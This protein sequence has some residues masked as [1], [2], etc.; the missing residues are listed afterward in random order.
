MSLHQIIY[1]SCK[2][3]IN[4]VNDGQQVFSYDASFKDASGD[5]VKRLFTYQ[6]PML[7]V[8]VIMTEEL[9]LTFPKSFIYR[10]MDNGACALTLNTYLGRDYMGSAG[11]FGN[12]LSHVVYCDDG[13]LPYYPAEFFGSSMLRDHMEYDEV[14]N[15]DKPDFLPEPVCERGYLV[16][17]DAV[18]EFLGIEDRLEI[19]KNMLHAVL[20][21]ETE[22]K[23]VVICDEPENVIL[24]IA[25]IQYALPLEFAL[26]INFSTYEFDPS[27]SYSQICGVIPKG[28]RYTPESRK[29]HFTFDLYD[30]VCAEF[31]KDI[32]FFDFIDTAFSFSYESLQ[33]FH[34]FILDGY[35]CDKAD[36]RMYAAYRLYTM[37][38]DGLASL[39]DE[40]IKSALEF[41]TQ[42]AKPAEHARIAE[43]LF[44]QK[45]NILRAKGGTFLVVMKYLMSENISLSEEQ[46]SLIKR[47]YVN[48][49]LIELMTNQSGENDYMEFY[50][51]ALSTSSAAGM[52]LDQEL[53]KP[54]NH[55]KLLK[56]VEN[57]T[58]TWKIAFVISKISEYVKSTHVPIE[59]LAFE[60]SLGQTYDNLVRST[61]TNSSK[62]GYFLVTRILNS[63]ASDCTYLINMTLNMEGTILDLPDGEREAA[64]MWKYWGQL[65]VEH[66]S[67]H[68]GKACE[69]LNDFER[70][71]EIF[72]LYTLAIA[73]VNEPGALQNLFEEHYNGFAKKHPEYAQA[74]ASK[75][76]ESYYAKLKDSRNEAAQKAK[77]ALFEFVKSNKMDV[78]F[79]ENLVADLVLVIPFDTPS[80]EHGYLID[81]C[82]AYLHDQMKKPVRGKLLI[83]KI[84]H[85]LGKCK[86]SSAF[87]D[88]LD[89]LEKLTADQK[90]NL[91]PVSSQGL[92]DYLEWLLPKVCDHCQKTE[93]M[94]RVYNLFEM[95]RNAQEQYFATCAKIY[96]KQ[97]KDEKDYAALCEFLGFVFTLGTPNVREEVGK[98]LRKLNKQK[99]TALDEEVKE[100][101]KKDSSAL[102]YWHDIKEVAQESSGLMSSMTNQL[103]NITDLFKKKK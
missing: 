42:Y 76:I 65:M 43:C 37:L 60:T 34:R 46:E 57:E 85:A 97:S 39:S 56:V 78:P 100:R 53:A 98:S 79:I 68:F 66:H 103:K 2:R 20:A 77:A 82:F 84:A 61:Y 75:I 27:L 99:L 11:R 59:E 41:A 69:V 33:D 19:F 95:P 91:A 13:N 72:T 35:T 73:A 45:E 74:Y 9:A 26:G 51:E 36:V 93:E 67:G 64:A 52:R 15:P 80:E 38:S 49:V 88:T 4:G 55:P 83:L 81:E 16:D 86:R 58:E 63:F 29:L 22:R 96:L 18:I 102:R 70:Y 50:S 28:T 71:D 54:A 14:N 40:E 101:F 21:F 6:P 30:Q 87:H 94:C 5:Q 1:T 47:L 7:D 8:G 17:I 90:A 10:K 23:R 12:H 48:K 24:W 31:D 44:D 25:A 92:N 3:G 62:N 89:E 32:H